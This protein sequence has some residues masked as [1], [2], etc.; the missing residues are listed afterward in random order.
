MAA[1]VLHGI[2]VVPIP[3]PCA[4]VAALVA[5]G[6]PTDDFRFVGFLPAKSPARRKALGALRQDPATLVV[7]VSPHSALA[8]LADV[9]A[10]LGADRRVSLGR[11]LTKVHETHVRGT[12]ADVLQR[13]QDGGDVKVR[14]TDAWRVVMGRGTG[15]W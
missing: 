13:L 14:C 1:C 2:D 11:E 15:L 10:E 7:Y 3:G 4:A 6:L 8:V 12:V 9:A 5:S